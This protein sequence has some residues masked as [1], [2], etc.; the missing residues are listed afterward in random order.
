MDPRPSHTGEAHGC[1][2]DPRGLDP[3]GGGQILIGFDV[4]PLKRGDDKQ[5][6]RLETR[7]LLSPFLSGNSHGDGGWRYF[8][9]SE[10][11]PTPIPLESPR[12]LPFS[13]STGRSDARL[14]FPETD[15]SE[16]LS[17]VFPK[18]L[19]ENRDIPWKGPL[20][21]ARWRRRAPKL[22]RLI[23]DLQLR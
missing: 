19:Q 7:P 8:F 23:W 13:D 11:R 14:E 21:E 1:P 20:T 5:R 15:R 4:W 16:S 18:P 12:L 9:E 22:P 3:E 17:A 10:S 2:R 6:I